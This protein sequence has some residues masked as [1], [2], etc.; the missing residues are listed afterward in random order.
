MHK[1]S[2]ILAAREKGVLGSQQIKI[3]EVGGVG[4]RAFDLDLKVSKANL[5]TISKTWL[6]V[7]ST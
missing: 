2:K 5:S 7:N 3:V 4:G 1:F 6:Q